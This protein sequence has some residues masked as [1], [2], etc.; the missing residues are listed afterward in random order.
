MIVQDSLIPTVAQCLA[1]NGQKC[2]T[3]IPTDGIGPDNSLKSGHE[4]TIF[5]I[6]DLE[7]QKYILSCECFC[8]LIG[9][10]LKEKSLSSSQVFESF[11]VQICKAPAYCSTQFWTNEGALSFNC[12]DELLNTS[13]DKFHVLCFVKKQNSQQVKQGKCCTNRSF[14]YKREREINLDF[15]F[16]VQVS[17]TYYYSLHSVLNENLVEKYF[18]SSLILKCT[19]ICTLITLDILLVKL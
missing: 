17:F 18:F 10:S 5:N 6:C 16:V 15:A 12:P 3:L 8:L 14:I 7:Y 1:V 9:Q 19:A 2:Y 11:I 4:A 13:G